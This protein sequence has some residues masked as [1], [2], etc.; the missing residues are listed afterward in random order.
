MA[1]LID[2]TGIWGLYFFNSKY[3]EFMKKLHS[4][5]ELIVPKIILVELIYP[6]YNAEGI[7]EM[8]KLGK[9]LDVL[10]TAENITIFEE[11][12][13]DV[14]SALDLCVL[15]EDLFITEKG[16]L[17]LFDS[18]LASIWKR[19]GLVLYTRDRSLKKFGKTYNLKYKNIE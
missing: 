6:V 12:V 3:H 4:T 7:T 18:I 16:N 9:F 14:T 2:T 13:D 10:K 19:T 5:T 15:H 17:S 11:T 1:V 8:Q